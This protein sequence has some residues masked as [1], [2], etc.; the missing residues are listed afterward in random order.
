MILRAFSQARF[1]AQRG[2]DA[3]AFPI[4]APRIEPLAGRQSVK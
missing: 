2:T 3:K 4:V 1:A